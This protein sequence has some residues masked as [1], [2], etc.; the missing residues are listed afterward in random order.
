MGAKLPFA[1][2]AFSDVEEDVRR[3]VT[4]IRTCRFLPHRDV[5]RGFV[6][7]V[8]TGRMREVT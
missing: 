2:G 6:Y 8:A 3:S 5:V 7:E 4:L 1:L